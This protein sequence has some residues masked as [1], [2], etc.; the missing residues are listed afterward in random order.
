MFV[1][2]FLMHRAVYCSGQEC[3]YLVMLITPTL[4]ICCWD[5]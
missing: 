3:K 4:N 1:T 5:S 2:A